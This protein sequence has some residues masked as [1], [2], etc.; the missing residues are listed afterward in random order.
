M[1]DLQTQFEAAAQTVQ[2]LAR[3]PDDQSLLKVYA[4]YKQATAGDVQGSR[5]G[6]M[7][8]AGRFKYDAWAKLKGTGQEAAMQQYVD[9][10][11]Q[12][13]AKYG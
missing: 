9:F 7:D 13:K 6:F 3:R 8:M 4:L 12:L 5:P 10:V 1:S 11:G 2:N